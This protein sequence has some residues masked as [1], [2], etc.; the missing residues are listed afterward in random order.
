MYS[1]RWEKG[2]NESLR[3]HGANEKKLMYGLLHSPIFKAVLLQ[4]PRYV[5]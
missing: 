1:A 5:E 4:H 2:N 3:T